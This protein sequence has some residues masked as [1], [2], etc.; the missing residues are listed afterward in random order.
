[1][2]NTSLKTISFFTFLSLVI[3]SSCQRETSDNVNQDKIYTEYELFYNANEDKTYA[4]AIFRF[5]NALGTNLELADGSEVRFEGDVLTWKPVFAYYE[6]EYAGF[7]T[8][9]TF[10]WD[11]L[12]GNSFSNAISINE[13]QY[14]LGIDS[15]GRDAAFELTWDGAPL[16]NDESVTVTVNG[17]NEG[18]AK[19]FLTDNVGSN[20]IILDKDKL[21]GVGAGPG[22]IWMDRH[23][24]P[25]LLQETSAG[26]KITGRY[27]PDNLE[28][29]FN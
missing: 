6:R 12:D 11:D 25:M 28:V 21:E 7:K 5:S 29:I 1:M 24:S 3:F 22:K 10:V 27:R 20:S 4:R 9:G 26:G 15:I 2:K 13:I 23:Y 19:I 16:A 14:P 17:E 18:D 8:S